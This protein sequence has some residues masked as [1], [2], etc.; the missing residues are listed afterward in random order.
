VDAL[1]RAGVVRLAFRRG[2]GAELHNGVLV[3]TWADEQAT[4]PLAAGPEPPPCDQPL[5]LALADEVGCIAG[6]LDAE[7][8]R[9]RLEH[10]D[11]GLASRV[12]ALPTFQAGAGIAPAGQR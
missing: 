5:P 7:A 10:C 3:R 9:V 4:L 8:A 11:G 12:G 1:R 6:W 2:G